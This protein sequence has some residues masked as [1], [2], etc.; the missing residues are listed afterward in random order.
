MSVSFRACARTDAGRVRR[1]DEDAFLIDESNA[2][3]AVADGV[4]GHRA[5]EIASQIAVQTLARVVTGAR[6]G[7]TFSPA[8]ALTMAFS[9]A[10]EEISLYAVAQP[11]AFGLATTLVAFLGLSGSAVVA[12]LGDSRAYLLRDNFLTLLTRDHSAL[13]DLALRDPGIDLA[14]LRKSPLAHVLTRCLGK[15]EDPAPDLAT[16]D[17]EPGDR[18][19]L[20]CDGLTDM[21]PESDIERVL[22]S[23]RDREACSQ[24]LIDAA[25]FAGGEDNITVLVIDA[26]GV[27]PI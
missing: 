6:R 4:G 7:L 22:S 23:I 1:R 9:Q 25:N 8:S 16:I 27:E 13:S 5:G 3:F 17:V 2:V 11:E 20:C 24:A 26:E 21:V 15:E 18:V 19:L 14:R 12:H 10:N